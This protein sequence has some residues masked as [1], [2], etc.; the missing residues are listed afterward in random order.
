MKYIKLTWNKINNFNFWLMSGLANAN[1]TA[2]TFYL[3]TFAVLKT[4]S[5]Q[6]PAD[7]IGWINFVIQTLYQGAALPLISFVAK[8]EGAKQA[9]VILD[10]HETQLKEFAE[11]KE[12]HTELRSDYKTLIDTLYLILNKEE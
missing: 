2:W 11:I 1:A 9:K 8:L 5:F 10:T 12:L 6:H 7:A 4:L 3:V